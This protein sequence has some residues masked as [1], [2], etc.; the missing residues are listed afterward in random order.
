MIGERN[1]LLQTLKG[2]KKKRVDVTR[3]YKTEM[4]H[5]ESKEE[6]LKEDF[7]LLN[8]EFELIE[9][10]REVLFR[11][12]AFVDAELHTEEEKLRA[13]RAEVERYRK[14]LSKML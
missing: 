2:L 11:E 4:F 12:V 14:Q 1:G 9:Q 8:E 3:K 6:H 10:E 7:G 5:M 13:G